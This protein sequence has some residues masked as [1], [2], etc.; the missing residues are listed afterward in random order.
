[1]EES[2]AGVFLFL[3]FDLRF[4]S[5]AGS[6]VMIPIAVRVL[7]ASPVIVP[8]LLFMLPLQRMRLFTTS[9]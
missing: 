1:M 6:F 5:L 3:D 8:F 2:S 7:G 4:T 9:A